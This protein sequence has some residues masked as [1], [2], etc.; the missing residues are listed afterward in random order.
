MKT[1]FDVEAAIA[2]TNNLYNEQIAVL[3][4]ERDRQI[5]ELRLFAAKQTKTIEPMWHEIKAPRR[6]PPF[7]KKG[8]ELDEAVLVALAAN[9]G[10]MDTRRL[11]QTLA[12]VEVGGPIVA[13]TRARNALY[14]SICRLLYAGRVRCLEA[15]V[16]AIPSVYEL[17]R[18]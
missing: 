3:K 17:V 2:K 15:S 4:R 7:G 16:G 13:G 14:A 11:F 5:G 18:S 12:G 10:R 8:W 6:Q 9:G 1:A